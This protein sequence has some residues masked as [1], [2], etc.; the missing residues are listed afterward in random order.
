M[1]D[2]VEVKRN[3]IFT[4]SKIIAEGTNNQYESVAA[5]IQKYWSDI[6]D[7]GS[8]EFSDLKSGNSKG[9]RPVRIYYLNEEQATFIFPNL[10]SREW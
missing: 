8:L 6:T 10:L 7:F 5:I 9:G 4:T 2:L 3:E 1:Y